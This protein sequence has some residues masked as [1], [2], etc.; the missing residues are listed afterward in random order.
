M[1]LVEDLRVAG[2]VD[3][4]ESHGIHPIIMERDA[5]RR[6]KQKIRERVWNLIERKK[7]GRFPGIQGRIPN[8][9]GAEK[10]S[11][12]L[13]EL[14]VWRKAR[15]IKA[16]PDSPQAPARKRAL[17]EGKIVYMAVPRLREKECFL[18]LDPKKIQDLRKASSI[19][20]AFE[21][22]RPVEIQDMRDI[23]LVLCGSV[24]VTRDGGRLGK[25]GGFSDLEYGLLREADKITANTPVVTTVHPLQIVD[26]IPTLEH[27]F[28]LNYIVTPAEILAC[29]HER[30]RPRGIYRDL[31]DPE[32]AAEIPC[33]QFL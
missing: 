22:G 1:T 29:H 18:E 21:V 6:Q 12:R 11:A 15:C 10:A 19:K 4:R 26:E 30:P 25:G 13:E 27:D 7:V 8:F 33:L 3:T 31:L 9:V 14:E 24:A 32:K 28:P 17:I 2:E 5:A 23:D 20:G 16:N